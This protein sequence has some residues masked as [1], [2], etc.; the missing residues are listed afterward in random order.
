MVTR[1]AK[2]SKLVRKKEHTAPN[3]CFRLGGDRT[4]QTHGA[5]GGKYTKTTKL[6]AE[7]SVGTKASAATPAT[8]NQLVIELNQTNDSFSKKESDGESSDEFYSRSSSLSASSDEDGQ[9]SQP[10]GSG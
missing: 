7:L 9:A 6:G 4:V 1:R 8:A 3:M 5:N 2:G 10:A